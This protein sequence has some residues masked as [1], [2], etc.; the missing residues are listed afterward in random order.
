[1]YSPEKIKQLLMQDIDDLVSRPELYARN[2]AKDFTRNRVITAKDIIQFPILMEHESMKRELLKYYDYSEDTPYFSA[3]YQQRRK[4]L[5]DT[6][7]HLLYSFNNHFTPALFKGKYVLTAVDGSSFSIF[8]NPKD[9][10]THIKPNKTSPKGHNEIH[11]VAAYHIQ[12]R[13]FADAVIQP[14]P[15]KNEYAA[16]CALIDRCNTSA[17]TP[18]FIADRGFPSYNVYAHCF[19]NKVFFLFRAKDLYI[20][21]LLG[22]DYPKD[23]DEFDI[24]VSRI[25]VRSQNKKFRSKPDN[26]ELYK[27]IN[28][29]VAFDYIAPGEKAEYPLTL[30]IVRIKIK[31][32][33]YENLIT[34]L[35]PEEFEPDDLRDLYTLRWKQETSFR[36]LKHAVGAEDF[37]CRSFEYICHEVWARL[38][39]YN[40]CSRITALVVI[41]KTGKKHSHQVNYT[42]AIKNSHDFLRQKP[43]DPPINILGLIG[44]YTE[45]IR[46]GRNFARNHR[47]HAPMKFT[48]RH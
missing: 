17:G 32:D 2:P 48:Y 21:R 45:P 40:F 20:K 27:C 22:D 38:I 25:V 36:E 10:L 24:T 23:K 12:D 16:I 4:L 11:V 18:L 8:Y 6:F 35:P 7:S 33:T 41:T 15:K 13:I 1:M 34:N 26:P 47:F 9:P 5:P 30:R 42:M 31:E 44:K 39:L 46:P 37:H 19:E 43:R 29:D 14:S 3:Y 28:A